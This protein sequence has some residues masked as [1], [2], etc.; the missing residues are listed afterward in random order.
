MRALDIGVEVNDLTFF[1]PLKVPFING[2]VSSNLT[3]LKNTERHSNRQLADLN[4]H[5]PVT[6]L[7][8]RNI[9]AKQWHSHLFTPPG[10][11]L[12]GVTLGVIMP[13]VKQ[14]FVLTRFNSAVAA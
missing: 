10:K 12:G 11:Q 5:P 8:N 9:L 14:L 6:H 2:L 3:N 1:E 7:V 13:R 4:V